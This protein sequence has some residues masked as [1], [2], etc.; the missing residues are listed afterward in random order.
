M[1]NQTELSSTEAARLWHDSC[2][3]RRAIFGRVINTRAL[4]TYKPSLVSGALNEN[5]ADQQQKGYDSTRTFQ[6]RRILT[7]MTLL[8]YHRQKMDTLSSSLSYFVYFYQLLRWFSCHTALLPPFLFFRAFW[9]ASCWET[10]NFVTVWIW[11]LF[12]LLR[13]DLCSSAFYLF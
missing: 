2:F 11:F 12:N 8:Y 13:S 9:G 5:M 6:R 7:H 10:R 1:S 4:C 3:K